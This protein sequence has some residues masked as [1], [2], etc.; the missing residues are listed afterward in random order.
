M[1]SEFKDC[2][3]RGYLRKVPSSKEKAEGSIKNADMWLKEAE[4]N[5]KH[6]AFNSSVL[7]SYLAMFHSAR[8]IL[9]HDGYREKNHYCVARYLE[10]KYVKENKLEEKWINLLDHYRS[11]RHRNQYNIGF[12]TSE[13]EA[14]RTLKSAKDFT[15]VMMELLKRLK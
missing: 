9:F 10:E 6:G 7:S 2:L 14:E 11:L 12:S 4:T 8:S 13:K 5:F 3:D 1:S 15:E